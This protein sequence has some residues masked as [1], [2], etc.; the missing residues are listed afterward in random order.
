MSIAW[1]SLQSSK[2]TSSAKRNHRHIWPDLAF[3]N[4]H[5]LPNVFSSRAASRKPYGNFV[6]CRRGTVGTRACPFRIV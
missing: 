2:D 4:S 1:A 3:E 6:Y 5:A